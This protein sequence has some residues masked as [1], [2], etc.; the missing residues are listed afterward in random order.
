MPKLTTPEVEC[1]V[2]KHFGYRNNLIVPNVH[3][4]MEIHE[5]DLLIVTR[6][7]YAYEVE[8]KVTKADLKKDAGKG[9]GH[10]DNRIKYLY[11]AIPDYLEECIDLVPERAGV[12]LVDSKPL[13][14][15]TYR[16]R[17]HTWSRRCDVVRQPEINM[18]AKP[19][20]DE[21]RYKVARLGALRIWRLKEKLV[22]ATAV[23]DQRSD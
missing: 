10:H 18:L 5:C 8:I 20:S 3:W 13:Q 16:G 1:A 7:G 22:D 21:E 23:K 17:K 9:H 14:T 4:G 19:F 12:M 6:R 11:F 15:T 2:A